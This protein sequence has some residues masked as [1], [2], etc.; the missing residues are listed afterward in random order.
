ANL[1]S[2][3]GDWTAQPAVNYA[4]G[5]LASYSA[6]VYIGS[7]YDEPLPLAFL[8]DVAATTKPVV[9]MYDNIWQL[10]APDTTFTA[11]HGFTWTGF[12]FSSV[13]T[14]DYQSKAF[15][16]DP[17]NGAGIMGTSITDPAKA[18]SIGD[19]VRADGSTMPWGVKSGN[20]TYVGEIPYAYM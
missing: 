5:E 20:F 4:A 15:T 1:S 8:D 9:W 6:V 16:R 19:A 14:V 18:T 17:E 11:D 10:T 7:T 3:F 2:H 13:S 12:D